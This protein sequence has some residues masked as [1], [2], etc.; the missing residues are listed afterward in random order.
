MADDEPT[1]A[2]LR[3]RRRHEAG[4]RF[5]C[6]PGGGEEPAEEEEARRLVEWRRHR[7]RTWTPAGCGDL[8][9]ALE[10]AASTL[11]LGFVLLVTPGE[12]CF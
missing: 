12:L 1:S 4:L 9:R 3:L 6:G 10:M 2:E 5:G 11:L 7:L 8:R